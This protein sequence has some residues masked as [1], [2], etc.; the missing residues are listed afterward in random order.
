MKEFYIG[1]ANIVMLIVI[2]I[3]VNSR[4]FN[5]EKYIS[6]C[7]CVTRVQKPCM[8]KCMTDGSLEECNRDCGEALNDCQARC[9]ETEDYNNRTQKEK[10]RRIREEVQ[11]RQFREVSE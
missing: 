7:D 8:D 10:D 4:D 1:I 3:K 6:D 2:L 9:M 5:R 11:R